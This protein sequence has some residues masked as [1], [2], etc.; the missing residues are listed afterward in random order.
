MRDDYATVRNT[1]HRLI[2]RVSRRSLIV[3][4][5]SGGL[6]AAR[7]PHA[8]F[9]FAD[10]H[11]MGHDEKA[12]LM[13]TL[14]AE[15]TRSE[16]TAGF[17]FL[18]ELA[19]VSVVLMWSTSHIVTKAVY[20]QI[21]PM[22]MTFLRFAL[23]TL[24]AF[25]VL[26]IRGKPGTRGIRRSDLPRFIM[27]GLTGYTIYQL[28]YALG[29][30]LTSPFSSALLIAMVPLISV[31]ILAATG[32][33]SG[34]RAWIGLGIALIG[35]VIFLWGKQ[36]GASGSLWG[37]LLSFGA[38]VSFAIYGI[39]N[40]PLVHRYPAET[41]SAYTLLAGTI[42]L[43]L[44]TLPGTLAQDWGS[45]N[46]AGWLSVLYTVIFPV[47]LAYMFWNFGIAKRGVAAA[48]SFQLL[49]PIT[50]GILAAVFLSEV[51]GPFK[52]LGGAIVLAGLVVV[53]T[54]GQNQSTAL[55]RKEKPA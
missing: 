6:G 32:E 3:R 2:S 11:A 7:P 38:A 18:P 5:T 16:G 55:K 9:A 24:L 37:D 8:R 17:R 10:W 1:G 30:D 26:L 29:L 27:A 35:V 48:T 20:T 47:Y 53:R 15:Q 43:L 25:T 49:V 51:F 50:S 46:T 54:R 42:P 39:V 14:A 36:D 40:R 41:Y 19:L 4:S 22:A 44:V 33:P 31:I 45:V 28:C 34:A 21:N 12:S 13:S 23:I 52:L